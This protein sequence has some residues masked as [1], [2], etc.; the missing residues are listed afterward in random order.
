MSRGIG[1]RVIQ[2]RENHLGEAGYIMDVV[3][4]NMTFLVKDQQSSFYI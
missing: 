2:S 4:G 1:G 3:A